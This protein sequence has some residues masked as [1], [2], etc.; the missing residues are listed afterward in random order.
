M[1]DNLEKK[2]LNAKLISDGFDVRASIPNEELPE[3]LT[4][5]MIEFARGKYEDMQIVPS[6]IALG[7][8]EWQLEKPSHIVYVKYNPNHLDYKLNSIR[9]V[10]P[11][12]IHKKTGEYNSALSLHRI[13]D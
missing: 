4:E 12:F 8:Y 11:G 5:L 13:N 3:S 1:T 10:Q 2:T 7:N 6:E 9:I